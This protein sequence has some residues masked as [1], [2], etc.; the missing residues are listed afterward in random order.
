MPAKDLYHDIVVDALIA[1]GWTI[2]DDPL[3]IGYGDKEFYVDLGA[4]DQTLAAEKGSEKIAVEIKSFVHRS[5]SQDLEKALGQYDVYDAILQE[6]EPER[7]LYLAVSQTA[8][9]ENFDDPLGRLLRRKRQLYFIVFSIQERKVVQWIKP[10]DT[11]I[12]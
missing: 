11:A 2:T 6:L 3:I 9:E 8:F 4:E 1:E 7:T 5:A 10:Q 12:S